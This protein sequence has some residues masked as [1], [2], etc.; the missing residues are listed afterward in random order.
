[1]VNLKST[2]RFCVL[3][4]EKNFL[5]VA[6]GYLSKY[7]PEFNGYYFTDPEKVY[8][9]AEEDLLTLYIIDMNLGE[10]NGMEIYRKIASISYKARVIF[11]TG[12][13]HF[14]EDEEIR[15]QT[16]SEGGM[17]F[18]EKPI[19]WHEMAI[20]IKN[21]LHILEYQFQLE[22]KVEERTQMLIHADRLAT[23]G[24]MVS[25]IVHEISSPLTFI[26]ANQETFLYAYSKMKD[27]LKD[28]PAK[29]VFENFILPGVEDSLNGI[30]RIEELLKS[31]RRFYKKEQKIAVNDMSSVINEV[32]NL[33]YYG[34][35]KGAVDFSFKIAEDSST[36]IKCN[37]QELVQILTNI[38]NNAIDALE[39]NGTEKK[40]LKIDVSSNENY[41]R[42][43][44]SN[45]GPA[46]PEEVLSEMF[47]P[48]FTTKT[49]DK[50]T[51][52]GLM[53]VRQI[54]KA[55]GGQIYVL[56]RT[57]TKE[58]VDF[59]LELPINQDP[60]IN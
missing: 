17:D 48:F 15:R 11:I 19:K 18:I 43:T 58:T 53:I 33:T 22:D 21:H 55:M 51:G 24:T 47:N 57:E 13:A 12:D 54:V 28:P 40:E 5:N 45:N 41:V 31:F 3:D 30:K 25:S 39:E 23:V 27:S 29:S 4:D 2:L 60:K 7:L 9:F 34:L 38:V 50:G 49:E 35:K 59:V 1:M 46:I 32:K 14:L 37:K 26:K 8:K 6:K 20:K 52:L 42:I 44:V 10:H 56:N 36:S 16:L